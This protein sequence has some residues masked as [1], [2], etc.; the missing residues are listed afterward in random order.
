M[1]LIPKT[2]CDT[3]SFPFVKQPEEILTETRNVN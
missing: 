2:V 1:S 3:S